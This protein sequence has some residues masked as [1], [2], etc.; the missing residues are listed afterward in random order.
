MSKRFSIVLRTIHSCLVAYAFCFFLTDCLIVHA[1]EPGVLSVILMLPIIVYSFLS[2]IYSKHFYTYLLFQ[3]PT[4][5]FSIVLGGV[6]GE[7]VPFFLTCA[8]MIACQII[9]MKSPLLAVLRP[10]GVMMGYFVFL[11][12]VCVFY[13]GENGATFMVYALMAEILIYVLYENNEGLHDFLQVRQNVRA[14][15]YRQILLS[16]WMIMACMLML[17]AVIF[18]LTG[19]FMDNSPILVLGTFLA[20]ILRTF[21][22][23]LLGMEDSVNEESSTSTGV[24][25]VDIEDSTSASSEVSLSG[26]ASALV[27]M[28][29]YAVLAV[30]GVILLIIIIRDLWKLI[31]EYVKEKAEKKPEDEET[32]DEIT[33]IEDE[34]R[35]ARVR[36][37]DEKI[38]PVRKRYK[39]EIRR[40]RRENRRRGPVDETL[41]PTQIEEE[42]VYLGELSEEEKAHWRELHDSYEEDR[43]GKDD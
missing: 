32:E 9:E 27:E 40:K 5:V 15:P 22:R 30:I 29:A 2:F 25:S 37:S 21:F 26:D 4:L 36:R 33:N 24:T 20:G 23:W 3:I 41:N 1:E 34:I 13:G 12:F 35:S 42:S 17:L 16:N 31:T 11:Y 38:S 18:L 10:C 43:Y 7:R 19:L 8:L 6:A 14:L 39:R 28:T